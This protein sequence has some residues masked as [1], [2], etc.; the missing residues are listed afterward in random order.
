MILEARNDF[1]I[2]R[3]EDVEAK[4]GNIVVAHTRT[5][6]ILGGRVLSV[7]GGRVDWTDEVGRMP[8]EV[9]DKVAYLKLT[10]HDFPPE[11][12]ADLTSVRAVDIVGVIG[13][14]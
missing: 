5:P 1:V 2:L 6:E 8:C 4:V 7:G 13:D 10:G 9:G 12:G 14:E 3:R 11:Y